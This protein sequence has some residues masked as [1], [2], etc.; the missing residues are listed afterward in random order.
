MRR[1]TSSASGAEPKATAR[2]GG[3]GRLHPPPDTTPSAYH[4]RTMAILTTSDPL[5]DQIVLNTLRAEH[6]TVMLEA[7]ATELDK[8]IVGIPAGE[9]LMGDEKHKVHVDDFLIDKYPVTNAVYRR[10]VLAANHRYPPDWREGRYPPGT[11]Q[12]PVVN[13][14]WA[15][16]AAF[17]A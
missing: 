5:D 9:F 15:D 7:L 3:L 17:A 4:S 2:A 10:F 13:V 8:R 14:S 12:L 1:Q 16:D 11:D 6:N